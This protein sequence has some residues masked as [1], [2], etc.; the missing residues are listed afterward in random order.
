M[1]TTEQTG[2]PGKYNRTPFGLV[3]AL[4]TTVVVVGGL[5]VFMGMFRHSTDIKP[6]PIDYLQAVRDA[7]PR[8]EPVYPTRLPEG[9]IATQAQVPDDNDGFEIDLLHGEHD[10]IGIRVAHVAPIAQLVHEGIDKDAVDAADY[11]VP[12]EIAAPLARHW[13]GFRDDGGDTGYGAVVG[14]LKVLVYGSAPAEQLQQVVDV[15]TTKLLP[16]KR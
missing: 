12:A 8:L 11:T 7:Q 5:L 16:E 13:D 10:F 14:R 15:L 4:V 1:S 9:Y 6:Q 3:A 2:R